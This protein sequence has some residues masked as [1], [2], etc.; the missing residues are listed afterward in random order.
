MWLYLA[1]VAAP[2]LLFQTSSYLCSLDIYAVRSPMPCCLARS[3]DLL[4][5]L[6]ALGEG[7]LGM[8]SLGISKIVSATRSYS[9]R[10]A[11]CGPSR[12]QLA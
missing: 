12:R 6:V 10:L 3:T 2:W 9:M 4:T 7:L 8:Y 11:L 1:S 5:A